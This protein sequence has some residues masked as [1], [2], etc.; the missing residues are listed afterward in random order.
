MWLPAS[1]SLHTVVLLTPGKCAARW[2]CFRV[3]SVLLRRRRSGWRG[4]RDRAAR[5][6]CSPRTRCGRRRGARSSGTRP[7]VIAVRSCGIVPGRSRKP[8]SP[9]AC[10]SSRRS[11]RPAGVPVKTCASDE[12]SAPDRSSSRALRPAAA[13]SLSSRN[14]TTSAK[15]CSVWS[16]APGQ[17]LL[18]PDGGND[19]RGLLAV[20]R[21]H[22]DDV[23]G[24]GGEPVR[25]GGVGQRGDRRL[26]LRRPR[27]DR[28]ALDGEPAAFE[29][30]VV[31]LLAVD[32]PAGG[33]VA[34]LGV[35]LPASPTAGAAPRRSPR[36]RRRGRPVGWACP[37][38]RSRRAGTRRTR[39]GRSAGCRRRARPPAR[40]PRPGRC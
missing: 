6:G 28:R 2:I 37:A 24:T 27:R 40:G 15:T 20:E 13:C 8:E 7:R 5:A 16:T 3:I 38:R 32:E 36:P 23:G 39:G 18:V 11:A 19:R 9:A 17:F 21:R 4:G 31:Q 35:V 34:D 33:D 14:T 22:V 1:G 10:Q 30:D 26:A 25:D 29:V 12:Y